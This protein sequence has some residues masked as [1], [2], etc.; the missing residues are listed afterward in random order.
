M[1]QINK[2]KIYVPNPKKEPLH[3]KAFKAKQ[4]LKIQFFTK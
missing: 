2:R 1:K 4:C 3:G